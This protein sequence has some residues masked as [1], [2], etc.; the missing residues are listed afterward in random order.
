MATQIE[1]EKTTK[2]LPAAIVGKF[3]LSIFQTKFQ[4]LV[5]EADKLSFAE[6]NVDNINSFFDKLKMVEKGIINTHKEGKEESLKTGRNWDAAKNAFLQL[7]NS[8]Y[9][10]KNKKRQELF[11]DIRRREEEQEKEKLR[12][13]NIKSGIEQNVISFAQ[14]IVSCTTIKELTE[15]E[16]IINL[17]KGRKEKYMEFLSEAAGKFS[18]L[19]KNISEQKDIIR[20]KEE[21]DKQ[22]EESKKIGKDEDAISLMDVSESM[23]NEIDKKKIEIQESAVNMQMEETPVLAPTIFPKVSVK[24]TTWEW[25]VLDI[26]E[27]LKKFPQFVDIVPNKEKINEYLKAKKAEGINANEFSFAGIRFYKKEVF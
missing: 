15:L 19:N 12:I 10:P 3:N 27:T 21:V 25:E 1:L 14:R 2:S 22:L 11:A 5:A 6:D 23:N 24:R 8:V 9:E 4:E 7:F 26:K 17:E 13:S 16:R 20:K 18:Q